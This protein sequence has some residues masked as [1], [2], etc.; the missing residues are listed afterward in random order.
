MA[1]TGIFADART[2]LA[3]SI[4]AL[5]LAAVLDS[6]NARPMS[7][8]INPPTFTCFNNNVA[9]IKFSLMILAAPPGS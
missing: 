8:L 5:G 9:D 1:A 3:A 2:T 6:R 4:T 7:V